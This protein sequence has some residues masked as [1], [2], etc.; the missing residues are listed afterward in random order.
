VSPAADGLSRFLSV[1]A[2]LVSLSALTVALVGLWRTHFARMHLL[3]ACGPAFIAVFPRRRENTETLVGR[4]VIHVACTNTGARAGRVRD[5]RLRVHHSGQ[6]SSQADAVVLP[7][8]EH[9][10]SD[11]P[12][13]R[14]SMMAVPSRQPASPVGAPFVLQAKETATRDLE[15]EIP[16]TNRPEGVVALRLDVRSDLSESWV[17]VDRWSLHLDERRWDAAVQGRPVYLRPNSQ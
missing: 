11:I 14:S 4:I 5:F 2:L 1:L 12:L 3:F 7:L 17:P 13:P 6:G 16:W 9:L 15:F 10:D 8:R